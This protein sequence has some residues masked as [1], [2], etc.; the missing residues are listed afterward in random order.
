MRSTP[1]TIGEV[2]RC[3]AGCAGET[4]VEVEDGIPVTATTVAE[5][6]A[7]SSWPPGDWVLDVPVKGDEQYSTVRLGWPSYTGL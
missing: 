2:R 4:R 5:L 3:I 1:K 6:R 7:L